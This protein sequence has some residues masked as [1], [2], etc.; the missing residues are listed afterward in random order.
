VIVN[1]GGSLIFALN[2]SLKFSTPCALPLLMC[3]RSKHRCDEETEEPGGHPVIV[4]RDCGAVLLS[5]PPFRAN[6][7][8]FLATRNTFCIYFKF[9]IYFRIPLQYVSSTRQF[10][11]KE[12]I[13]SKMQ[14]NLRTPSVMT[15]CS[16]ASA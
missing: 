5:D 10:R 12:N 6:K 8:S 11:R 15:C 16:F 4:R 2:F 13:S 14:T 7:A 9:W 3:F 1:C